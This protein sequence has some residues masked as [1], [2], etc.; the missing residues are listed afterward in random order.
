[1]GAGSAGSEH[2]AGQV[3]HMR[4]SG[5]LVRVRTC[6]AVCSIRYAGSEV[7]AAYAGPEDASAGLENKIWIV[8]CFTSRRPGQVLHMWG[9]RLLVGPGVVGHASRTD[10]WASAAH[11]GRQAACEEFKSCQGRK[12]GHGP[13]VQC[14]GVSVGQ[15]S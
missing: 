12:S 11:V 1:M 8:L 6:K 9:G 2:A 13:Q 5:P 10:G 7:H 4:R 15:S 14:M 3:L